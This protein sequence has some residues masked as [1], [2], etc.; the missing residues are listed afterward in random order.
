MASYLQHET[1]HC[2][3]LDMNNCYVT[4]IFS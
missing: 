1:F 3:S 2:D 4:P